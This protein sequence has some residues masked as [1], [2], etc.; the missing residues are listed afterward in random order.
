MNVQDFFSGKTRESVLLLTH[1]NADVDGVASL[2]VL[3]FY[4]KKL[5]FKNYDYSA[6]K[7]ISLQARELLKYADKEFVDP[8]PENYDIIATVDVSSPNQ[9]SDL[10]INPEKLVAIDHH[11]G[12]SLGGTSFMDSDAISTTEFLY[13]SFDIPIDRKIA[14]LIL[15]GIVFDSAYLRYASTKTFQTIAKLLDEFE[16]EYSEIISELS[17]EMSVSEKIARL[18]GAQRAKVVR[19]ANSIIATSRV[20]SFESAVAR[21]LVALGADVAFVAS[22]SDGARVSGRAHARFI[23]ERS[24]N[25]GKYIMPEV[26]KLLGGS[27]SGHEGAAGANG[28]NKDRINEALD[29]C[30]KLVQKTGKETGKGTRKRSRKKGGKK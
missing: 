22:D 6:P 26:G 14:R 20:G 10:K 9:L 8:E 27:G 17:T 23:K 1:H 15:A 4:L 16:L 7:D 30:V 25:L 28:P 11:Q 21:G 12:N 29:L 18:K 19:D 24:L 13:N 5:G 2:L 3:G